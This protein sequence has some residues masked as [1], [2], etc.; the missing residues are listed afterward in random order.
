MEIDAT[1]IG[2]VGIISMLVIKECFSFARS[3]NGNG[4]TDGNGFTKA[5]STMIVKLNELLIHQK[6]TVGLLEK[7][8]DKT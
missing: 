1:Q 3:R 6:R 7:L 5:E 4:K 8:V 2:I